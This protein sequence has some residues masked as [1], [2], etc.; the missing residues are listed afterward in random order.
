MSTPTEKPPAGEARARPSGAAF[1]DLNAL[2]VELAD[3]A[4]AFTQSIHR[5]EPQYRRLRLSERLQELRELF[6]DQRAE[7]GVLTDAHA[8]WRWE[9]VDVPDADPEKYKQW[10]CAKGEWDGVFVECLTRGAG[11]GMKGSRTWRAGNYSYGTMTFTS[12]PVGDLYADKA[13]ARHAEH[14]SRQLAGGAQ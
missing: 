8:L 12:P 5:G 9:R 3:V 14:A 11:D 1:P 4:V 6:G 10:R 13:L 7:L 2:A